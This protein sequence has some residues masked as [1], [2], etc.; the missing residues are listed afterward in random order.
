[1]GKSTNH[2]SLQLKK[3]K[4]NAF[5]RATILDQSVAGLVLSKILDISSHIANQMLIEG[6]HSKRMTCLAL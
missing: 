3:D 2:P 4:G 5:E 1:M 6:N